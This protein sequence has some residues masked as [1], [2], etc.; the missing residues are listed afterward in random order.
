MF[1]RLLILMIIT[2][3]SSISAFGTELNVMC[4]KGL[5]KVCKEAAKVFEEKTGN[6]IFLN[7]PSSGKLAMQIEAGIPADVFLLSDKRWGDFLA[8][9]GLLIEKSIKPFA[10]TTLLVVTRKD[11]SINTLDDLT[12]AD[13]IAVGDKFTV[14]GSRILQ[15][16]KALHL[17]NKLKDKFIPAPTVNQAALWA[18]TGNVNAAIIFNPTYLEFEKNLKV[19]YRFPS[20]TYDPIYFYTSIVESSQKKKVAEEFSEFLFSPTVKE[21]LKKYGFEPV[22]N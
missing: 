16:F 17:Y 9:E 1:W 2:F 11:S 20:N 6:K 10:S 19:V 14:I 21:I 7:F 22:N 4:A 13:R 8:R 3:F 12:K 15:A 18:S 5:I